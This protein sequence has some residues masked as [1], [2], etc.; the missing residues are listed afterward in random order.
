MGKLNKITNPK[1]SWSS[2]LYGTFLLQL[3]TVVHWLWYHWC[4]GAPMQTIWHHQHRQ[5]VVVSASFFTS[6]DQA[7]LLLRSKKCLLL[8][9][10]LH[11]QTLIRDLFECVIAA[12]HRYTLPPSHLLY[13]F[14]GDDKHGQYAISSSWTMKIGLLLSEISGTL[15]RSAFLQ[16]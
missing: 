4:Y 6:S 10:L 5:L 2:S 1:A 12:K 9:R 13:G 7:C 11:H 14:L 3:S 8:T 15:Y 16:K